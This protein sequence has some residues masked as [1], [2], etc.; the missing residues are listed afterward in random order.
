VSLP[1]CLVEV[2]ALTTVWSSLTQP[3]SPFQ[4]HSNGVYQY[5]QKRRSQRFLGASLLMIATVTLAASQAETS[6][7]TFSHL[8]HS[9]PQALLE[10]LRRTPSNEPAAVTLSRFKSNETV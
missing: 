5:C 8:S 9:A 10:V 6:L 4:G 1:S 2:V 7:G 3:L